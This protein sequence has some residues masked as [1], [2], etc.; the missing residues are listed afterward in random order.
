MMYNEGVRNKYIDYLQQW[1]RWKN[2]SG[3][4]TPGSRDN[5]LSRTAKRVAL[6]IRKHTSDPLWLLHE[7]RVFHI[8]DF[9]VPCRR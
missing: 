3:A 8:N 9:V 5:L 2:G 4:L 1:T 7:R 6:T